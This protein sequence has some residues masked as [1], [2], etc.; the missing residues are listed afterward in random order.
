MDITFEEALLLYAIHYECKHHGHASLE[1]I[2]AAED[3]INRS[4]PT[5]EELKRGLNI[6][7]SAGLIAQ[8][9]DGFSVTPRGERLCLSA[10]G[11]DETV[12]E[13]VKHLLERLQAEISSTDIED[14]IDLSEESYRQAYDAYYRK[15]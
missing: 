11:A 9:Q 15:D 12:F 13:T 14:A 10:G 7:I 4:A 1:R 2:L 5:Y 8:A 3:G 6:L